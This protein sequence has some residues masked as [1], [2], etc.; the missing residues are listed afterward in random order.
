MNWPSSYP[1]STFFRTF[2]SSHV[3]ILIVQNLA[4]LTLPATS[5]LGCFTSQRTVRECHIMHLAESIELCFPHCPGI[6]LLCPP[7]GNITCIILVL[8]MGISIHIPFSELIYLRFVLI[9]SFYFFS[10]FQILSFWD[11]SHPKCCPHLQ[12]VISA[13]E[14]EFHR[15]P[16]CSHVTWMSY[17]T[18]WESLARFFFLHHQS[19][20]PFAQA[21]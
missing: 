16:G 20:C 11:V 13:E 4:V 1:P 17:H 5:V 19:N 10:F 9:L 6:C 18:W 14:L 8:A 3:A 12:N 2:L 7:C 15:C 21:P